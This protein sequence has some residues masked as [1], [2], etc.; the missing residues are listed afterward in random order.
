MMMPFFVSIIAGKSYQPFNSERGGTVHEICE[1]PH[2]GMIMHP[3]VIGHT[4]E[5]AEVIDS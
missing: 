2:R 5:S 1:E 3:E 4:L